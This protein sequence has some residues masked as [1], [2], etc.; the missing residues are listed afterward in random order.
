LGRRGGI[1]GPY[2]YYGPYGVPGRSGRGVSYGR[3]GVSSGRYAATTNGPGRRAAEQR[4]ERAAV[5]VEHGD[6]L[7]DALISPPTDPC[8]RFSGTSA[9][10]REAGKSLGQT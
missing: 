8:A 5:H 1:Y 7:P 4:D 10:H 6:I 2:A 3:Y 9:C